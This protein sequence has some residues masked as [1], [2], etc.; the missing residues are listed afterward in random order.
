[1]LSQLPLKL[2]APSSQL[3]KLSETPRVSNKKPKLAR[4]SEVKD[5][6]DLK[7]D[8]EWEEVSEAV[9]VDDQ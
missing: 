3:I 8:P 1:M 7:L 2:P 9:E 5:I 6:P 4:D